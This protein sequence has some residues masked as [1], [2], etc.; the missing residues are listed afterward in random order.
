MQGLMRG[1]GLLDTA[2]QA[3]K[4]FGVGMRNAARLVH[5][6]NAYFEAAASQEAY[7]DLGADEIQILAA[8]DRVTC[9]TCGAPEGKVI[10]ETEMKPGI[11]VPPFHPNCR[12]TT[13]PYLPDFDDADRIARDRDGETYK[14]P[15]DMTYEEWKDRQKNMS[16]RT[17]SSN[18]DISTII[19]DGAE[20]DSE[21]GVPAKGSLITRK[22][23]DD[24]KQ[25]AEKAGI[26][27]GSVKG[28]EYGGFENFCGDVNDLRRVADHIERN[29]KDGIY[30]GKVSLVY[31]N[32]YT[33]DRRHE[34]I[35]GTTF[36][37]TRGHT[38][39]LNS[40]L[41]DDA[42]YVRKLYDKYAGNHIFADGTTADNVID[43]ETGHLRQRERKTHTDPVLSRLQKAARDANM[44]LREY[45]RTE[46]S[47]YAAS[48]DGDEFPELESE[49]CSKMRGSNPEGAFYLLTGRSAHE[50]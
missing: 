24:W 36:A 10:R 48:L 12:C 20:H 19:S 5:T 9:E 18:E 23:L 16:F 4:R 34:I 6:E 38:V 8:L 40:Y 14:V 32:I 2:S 11:T 42:A 22:Q 35:D 39:T 13:V 7:K 25:Y 21:L 49:L 44:E 45:I 33:D 43:H 29:H 47:E 1:K 30:T 17:P 46:V 50:N 31:S 15:A 26:R 37:Q 27:F 28:S 3:D 41:Y